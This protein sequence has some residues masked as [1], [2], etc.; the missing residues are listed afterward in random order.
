MTKISYLSARANYKI[1]RLANKINVGSGFYAPCIGALLLFLL[2]CS[3]LKKSLNNLDQNPVL[4]NSF[5]GFVLFDPE[6]NKILFDHQGSK[7]FTPASNTKLFT[8]YTANRILEDSIPAFQYRSQG[9][10]IWLWGTGDPSFL[11]PELPAST[12]YDFLQGKQIF[13]VRDRFD[14]PI[15]GPGW[16]WDDYSGSYQRAK[17]AFPIFGNAVH[18]SWDS[19]S[20]RALVNPPQY[21]DSI[22]FDQDQTGREISGNQFLVSQAW[23][24]GDTISIP[25]YTSESNYQKLWQ[26]TLHTNVRWVDFQE[27]TNTLVKHSIPTDSVFKRL[28]QLSDNFLAEQLILLCSW[29]LLGQLDS[30][31]TIA[32]LTDSLLIDLPQAPIWVDGSGLSRYN[33]FTPMSLVTLLHKI[34]QEVD[35]ER[36]FKLLPAGGKSGTIKDYYQADPPYIF[37]KTGT[38][39]NNH[40][41]SGYLITKRGKRLIFSFMHNHYPGSSIPVKREMEK[42]L[43]QIHSKY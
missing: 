12:I 8:F 24:K 30:D 9:D 4:A 2:S 23:Q 37:A 39:R 26:D 19:L 20:G 29:K 14:E 42:I 1:Y 16:A 38:L 34:Y 21:F 3:P 13:L 32:H 28:L 43:W 15:Y 25:L 10:S 11:N 31:S 7:Y 41:L 18:V 6:N 17:A 33:L 36:L 35:E 5:T 40:A 22:A 27:P